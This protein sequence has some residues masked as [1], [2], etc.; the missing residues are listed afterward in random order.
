LAKECPPNQKEGC[1]LL[2]AGVKLQVKPSATSLPPARR[3]L[4]KP[5]ADFAVKNCVKEGG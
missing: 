4:R 1:G 3:T 2:N 5:F